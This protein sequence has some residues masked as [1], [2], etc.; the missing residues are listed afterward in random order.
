MFNVSVS[1]MVPN[2]KIP[3]VVVDKHGN[4]KKKLKQNAGTSRI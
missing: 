1:I 2:R 3:K 4:Y